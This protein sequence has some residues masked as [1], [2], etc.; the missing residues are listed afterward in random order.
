MMK[1]H[2]AISFGAGAI[3]IGFK[4]R[5]DWPPNQMDV[6]MTAQPLCLFWQQKVCQ[7]LPLKSR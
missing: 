1:E 3:K 6:E 4:E 5:S 7:G 2:G